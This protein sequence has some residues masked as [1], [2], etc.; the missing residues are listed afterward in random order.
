M[1]FER[2]SIGTCFNRMVLRIFVFWK[3]SEEWERE[4]RR[5]S[6]IRVIY[7]VRFNFLKFLIIYI[8]Y[9][10]ILMWVFEDIRC[11]KIN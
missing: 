6:V 7:F 1:G 11:F 2:L 9:N 3:R 10:C 8:V 5:G 4:D